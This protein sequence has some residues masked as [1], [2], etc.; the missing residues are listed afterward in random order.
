MKRPV[1]ILPTGGSV[2]QIVNLAALTALRA[3]GEEFIF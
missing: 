1:N 3:Q 2:A